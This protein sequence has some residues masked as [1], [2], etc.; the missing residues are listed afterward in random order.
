MKLGWF[1]LRNFGN[2][3]IWA[4]STSIIHKSC[5]SFLSWTPLGQIILP[6]MNC[7]YPT[8]RK[9]AG[10]RP[11]EMNEFFSM[12]I[13]ILTTLGPGVYSASNRNQYQKQKNYVSG[14]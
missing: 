13:I 6:S 7:M 4:I 9:V 3:S 8:S 12:Y 11:N 2:Y 14:E 1:L 5:N 10:L